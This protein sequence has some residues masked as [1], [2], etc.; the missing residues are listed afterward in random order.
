M[1]LIHKNSKFKHNH[2]IVGYYSR[3]EIAEYLRKLEVGG[4]ILPVRNFMILT[5]GVVNYG[6]K[7]SQ[8]YKLYSKTITANKCI[9]GSRNFYNEGVMKQFDRDFFD[10]GLKIY[11]IK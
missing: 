1:I 4:D 3:E 8:E 6:N 10:K 9:N 7:L 2:E 11:D 5:D